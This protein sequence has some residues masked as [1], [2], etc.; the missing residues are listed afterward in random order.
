MSSYFRPHTRSRNHPLGKVATA[1]ALVSVLTLT[2]LPLS[3][4][5]AADAQAPSPQTLE[6]AADQMRTDAESVGD[7][8]ADTAKSAGDTIAETAK[9]A[10]DTISDAAKAA[11]N[12]ISEAAQTAKAKAEDMMAPAEEPS[13]EELS[14]QNLSSPLHEVIKGETT[15]YPAGWTGPASMPQDL[16]DMK[17]NHGE[18]GLAEVN[19]MLANGKGEIV[20]IIADPEGFMNLNLGTQD[21]VLP[22]THVT[23]EP[24][25]NAFQTTMTKAELLAL[26]AWN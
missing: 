22:L 7:K 6:G 10:G 9:T 15:A 8:I 13:G 24:T 16:V 25:Q 2:T 1:T 11:K 19:G 12:E 3:G 14:A 18:E 5:F 20:A 26:P 4:A 23:Y 21:V 17:I